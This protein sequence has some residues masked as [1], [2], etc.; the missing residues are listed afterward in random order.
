M[1]TYSHILPYICGNE[2]VKKG[3]RDMALYKEI[4]DDKGINS[5]YFRIS[6]VELDIDNKRLNI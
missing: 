4:T 2:L 1:E 3:E 6:K 5:K